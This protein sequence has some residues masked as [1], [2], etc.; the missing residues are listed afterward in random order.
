MTISPDDFVVSRLDVED[1]VHRLAGQISVGVGKL[2][3][4]NLDVGCK[5]W[6][7]PTIGSIALKKS[8]FLSSFTAI[9]FMTF[10]AAA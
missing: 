9:L 3:L 6:I 5:H 7:F 4:P 2:V 8:P 1:W 10:A